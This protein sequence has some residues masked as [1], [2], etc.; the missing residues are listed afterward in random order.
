MWTSQI[1]KPAPIKLSLADR[2][3]LRIKA[4][5]PTQFEHFAPSLIKAIYDDKDEFVTT[6]NGKVGD[7]GIDAVLKVKK[8]I[9][10]GVDEYFIQC[11]R[12]D[13][14]GV[15]GNDIQAFY[16]AMRCNSSNYGVFITTSHFTKGAE[17]AIHLLKNDCTI[18]KIDGEELVNYML[19]HKIGI[20]EIPQNPIFEIDEEF[21][22]QFS[23]K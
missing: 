8:K 12:Y 5:T 16:G 21:F 3:L 23:D 9:G 22:S 18:I 14:T 13:K 4:L 1:T 20:K 19:K 17:K 7:G 11:K 10:A 6:H 2:I 15:S